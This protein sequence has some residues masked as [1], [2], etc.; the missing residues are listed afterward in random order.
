MAKNWVV[1]RLIQSMKSSTFFISNCYKKNL[2]FLSLAIV[3]TKTY[4]CLLHALKLTKY[5]IFMFILL[6]LET[7]RILHD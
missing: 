6:P 2:V 7:W 1:I 4:L 5:K 3:H